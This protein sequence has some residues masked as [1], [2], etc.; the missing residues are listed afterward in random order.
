MKESS[1]PLEKLRKCKADPSRGARR[2][3]L[4]LSD[5][6]AH[7]RARWQTDTHID[8]CSEVAGDVEQAPSRKAARRTPIS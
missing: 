7:W 4:G 8:G 1:H 6:D 3:A 5:T 2:K